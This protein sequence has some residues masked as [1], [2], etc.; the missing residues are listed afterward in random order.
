MTTAAAIIVRQKL[1]SVAII[2][3]GGTNHAI[4]AV[5]ASGARYHL[6]HS[7]TC[8]AAAEA[9][10]AKIRAKGS[11]DE[12]FWDL[13]GYVTASPADAYLAAKGRAEVARHTAAV[14][15]RLAA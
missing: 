8:K 10:A 2:H 1:A 13:V 15:A 6:Q 7:F 4:T 14:E 3:C 9:M 11:L 5:A 12:R